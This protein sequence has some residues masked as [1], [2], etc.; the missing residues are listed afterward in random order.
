MEAATEV[1][2]VIDKSEEKETGEQE[3]EEKK[4][5][6]HGKVEQSQSTVLPQCL[7][8]HSRSMAWCSDFL[9]LGNGYGQAEA[10]S[11]HACHRF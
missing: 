10:A 8:C 7:V 3:S 9:L 4:I 11:S 1:R 5:M 6:A 2:T